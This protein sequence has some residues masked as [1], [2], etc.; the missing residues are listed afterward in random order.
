MMRPVP[1]HTLEFKQGILLVKGSPENVKVVLR[2]LCPAPLTFSDTGGQSFQATESDACYSSYPMGTERLATRGYRQIFVIVAKF[3]NTA[4]MNLQAADAGFFK[5]G[6]P[7]FLDQ[8]HIAITLGTS[9]TLQA[10]KIRAGKRTAAALGGF[11]RGL[12]IH[13]PEPLPEKVE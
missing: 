12:Q 4:R 2:I 9:D 8:Q 11:H 3:F 7:I 1:D 10:R 13:A 6:V 5:K